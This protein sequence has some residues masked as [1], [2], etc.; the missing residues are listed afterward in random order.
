MNQEI[1]KEVGFM[2]ISANV[3]KEWNRMRKSKDLRWKY[4]IN[5]G[6]VAIFDTQQQERLLE[7]EKKITKMAI[8]L[9][10]YTQRVFDLEQKY[11]DKG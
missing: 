9:T 8:L 10:K 6:L 4:I 3:P 5:K 11:N 2:M 1:N 7:A